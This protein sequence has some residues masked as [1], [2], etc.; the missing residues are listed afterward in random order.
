MFAVCCVNTA[1]WRPVLTPSLQQWWRSWD[2]RSPR[3][4]TDTQS[5]FK[6]GLVLSY[7]AAA[8]SCLTGSSVTPEVLVF[9]TLKLDGQTTRCKGL[10]RKYTAL[11]KRTT[12]LFSKKPTLSFLLNKFYFV[13][14]LTLYKVHRGRVGREATAPH[15]NMLAAPD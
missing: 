9:A 1:A 13:V 15:K 2:T 6:I 11:L 14:L 5:V 3:S 4:V 12:L 10:V 7:K 8:C